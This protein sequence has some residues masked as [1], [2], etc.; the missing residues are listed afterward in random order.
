MEI[1][2]QSTPRA[3]L[4][5]RISS[6]TDDLGV[7]RQEQD[8]RALAERIGVDIVDTYT[9]NNRSAYTPG[10]PRTQWDRLVGDIKAGRVT[11]LIGWAPDRFTRQTRELEDLIDVIEE[12]SVA[13]HTVTAGVWDLTTPAGRM[14]ARQIGAV[15]RYE[16]ELKSQ[17]IKRQKEQAHAAG[18]WI[19]GAR[20][21]GYAPG[22]K[23]LVAEEAER[24]KDAAR[25][26]L[27]GETTGAIVA[28]WNSA[29]VVAARGTHWTVQSLRQLLTNPRIAGRATY[30]GEVT[31]PG[32]WP[33]IITP[34]QSEK[35]IRLYA[36]PARR[37]NHAGTA[38]KHELSGFLRCALPGEHET[39]HACASRMKAHAHHDYRRKTKS[40]VYRCDR[41]R[42]GACGKRVV[43]AAPVERI[44]LAELFATVADSGFLARLAERHR[45]DPAMVQAVKDDENQLSELADA[46]GS[47]Q[48]TMKEWLQARGPI[49]ARLTTNRAR[50]NASDPVK[51]LEGF[52]GTPE[53]LSAQ[54]ET[55][56]L[57]RKRAILG[58]VIEHVDVYPSTT[59]GRK[60]DTNRVR[61]AWRV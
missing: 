4:Y 34:E 18:K 2:A 42:A 43:S 53:E 44:V 37:T 38:R 19:G 20:L 27:A 52:H 61:I 54:W 31:G 11:A 30:K 9:D 1:T 23:G 33:R 24:V 21:Y 7:T 13:L 36:N 49:E 10:K 58:A 51:A 48:I 57:S 47:Q 12:H 25:R 28:E 8:N 46:Y 35:L 15:A 32:W 26:V 41:T 50:L 6:A 5:Q 16:S 14:V 40:L 3:A 60:F 55:L 39:A 56:T 29:G 22:M 59:T 17:R 45:V